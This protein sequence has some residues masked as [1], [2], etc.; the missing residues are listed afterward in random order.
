MSTTSILARLNAFH[1]VVPVTTVVFA[2]SFKAGGLGP[3]GLVVGAVAGL[4]WSLLLGFVTQRLNR[5]ASLRY[6]LE[7]L[8]VFLAIVGTAFLYVGG[9][10]YGLLFSAALNEPS[11]SPQVLSALMQP[12]IPY[13]IIVNTSMEAL[14]VPALL[15]VGWRAGK[16][17]TIIVAAALLY[18]GMRIWT[19]LVWAE[20]RVDLAAGP[21]SA[22]DIDRFKELMDNDRDILLV[23]MFALFI[24]AA[25]VPAWHRDRQ[26]ALPTNALTR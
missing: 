7:D 4:G 2:L 9:V 10:M 3:I 13:Y 16:R 17:R 11:T 19:Y 8:L 15:Y 23:P 5:Q 1:I 24:I 21:L 12:T 14:V 25:F 22:R 26:A 18:Y 6:K 20:A